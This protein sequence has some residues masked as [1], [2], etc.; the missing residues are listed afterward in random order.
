M[1]R[2][3]ETAK[4]ADKG[5]ARGKE[6]VRVKDAAKARDAARSRVAAKARPSRSLRL[7]RAQCRRAPA[8][9]DS[10]AR[11]RQGMSSLRQAP[12]AARCLPCTG[13]AGAAVDLLV[14]A[15]LRQSG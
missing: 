4:G 7:A 3:A 10:R 9:A 1:A 15:M 2:I 12:V 6:E 13:R 11:E 5:A 8:Q 14:V